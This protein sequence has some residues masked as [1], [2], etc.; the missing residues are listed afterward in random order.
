VVSFALS[1]SAAPWGE[2]AAGGTT[3]RCDR[4][5]HIASDCHAAL[6]V[7]SAFAP[8]NAVQL[9]GDIYLS[10]PSAKHSPD[11]SPSSARAH[12]QSHSGCREA[13]QRD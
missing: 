13:E 9:S 11:D 12:V 10:G 6:R 7:A 3:V 5:A 2:P 4:L 8:R 1:D